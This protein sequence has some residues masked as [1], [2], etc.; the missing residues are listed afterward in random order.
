MILVE[1]AELW[2]ERWAHVG[3]IVSVRMYPRTIVYFYIRTSENLV[4]VGSSRHKL[5][6]HRKNS[7]G[8]T[9][10]SGQNR[11]NTVCCRRHV[12]TCRRHFQLSDC[13]EPFSTHHCSP[14]PIGVAVL[15]A[16]LCTIHLIYW[17][18][19]SVSQ[20]SYLLF[21]MTTLSPRTPLPFVDSSLRLC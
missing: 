3:A 5:P 11:S 19:I 9:D 7:V 10:P 2:N 16:L 4:N 13:P 8:D 1:A 17:E 21:A 18:H 20:S 12:A 14:S 15:P 6:R